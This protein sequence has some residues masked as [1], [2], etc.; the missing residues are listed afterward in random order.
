MS[1]QTVKDILKSLTPTISVGVLTADVMK[2]GDELAALD[3]TGVGILHF[4]VMDGCF[5]PL[6]TFGASFIKGI[7][8]PLLKDV[9]LTIAD[10]LTKL[11]EYVDAGADILTV[12]LES[13]PTHIHRVFQSLAKMTNANDPERGIVRGIAINP[14]T[15]VQAIEPVLDDIDI[16]TIL[17]INPGWGGQKLIPSTAARVAQA[18]ELIAGRDI[19]LCVDGGVTKDNIAEVAAWGIDM[20]VTGSAVFDGKAPADN[21][22]FML[23]EFK[24]RG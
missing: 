13:E 10:P 6:M 8:T 9:H 18:K 22:R 16:V 3:G 11:A 7:K 20:V 21:A 5:C 23:E 14:G 15:P 24:R 17:G 4:D 12:Y 1:A 2:L 19:L